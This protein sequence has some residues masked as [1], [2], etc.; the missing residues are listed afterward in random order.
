MSNFDLFL[1]TLFIGM[2]ILM[3]WS[4]HK[5]SKKNYSRLLILIILTSAALI[6]LFQVKHAGPEGNSAAHSLITI[7]G[8]LAIYGLAT[9]LWLKINYVKTSK[10]AHIAMHVIAH[11]SLLIFIFLNY[12]IKNNYPVVSIL[13][14]PVC[15]FSLSLIEQS[16]QNALNDRDEK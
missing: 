11:S 10:A 2:S 6:V 5:L 3:V 16:I 15:A 12:W 14:Y 8:Q 9:K 4:G 1:T 7:L 13:V